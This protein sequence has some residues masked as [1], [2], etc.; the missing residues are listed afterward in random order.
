M[1]AAVFTA[2]EG[3]DAI[4]IQEQ[5]APTAGPGEAVV[6]VDACGL[7]R[8]DLWILEEGLGI[9][10]G[11]P[12]FVSGVDLAGV[13]ESVGEGA[14][15]RPGARVVLCPNETC[16][17]CRYC[18]EGPENMCE[19]FSLYHGGLA[20]YATVPADRLVELPEGLGT[21]EAAVLPVGHMTAWRML[22]NADVGPGDLVFV[23]GATGSVGV[24]T[25]QLAAAA[26]A[27]TVV[28]SSSAEKLAGLEALGADHTVEGR[29][30]ETLREAVEAVG[31]VDVA[32]NYL[33]GE[34][35]Q[36]CLSTLRRGGT[37]VTCGATAGTDSTVDIRSMYLD[38]LR[39]VASSMGTQG[40]LETAVELAA[41]GEFDPV[42]GDA[43]PLAATA[44]AFR[45]V[46]ESDVLG[47]VLVHPQ[48]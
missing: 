4:E 31:E 16:G 11:D 42:V 22:Q 7:N 39:V 19:A 35:S 32:V 5:R 14:D 30:P 44:D 40:D 34:Y 9:G 28:S 18:R 6:R 47:K 8:H 20:E 12:P 15:V 27:R 3:P 41:A 23:P 17:H 21:R 10:V 13:V 45:T 24:A 36:L 2:F 26:G 43:F 48:E 33:A 29:D 38:H 46:R 1:R 37:M 25:V